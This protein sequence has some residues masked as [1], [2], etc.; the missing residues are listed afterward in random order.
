MANQKRLGTHLLL[1]SL[2]MRYFARRSSSS[3]AYL[4]PPNHFSIKCACDDNNNAFHSFFETFGSTQPSSTFSKWLGH[5]A[6]LGIV[7]KISVST[8]DNFTN[9]AQCFYGFYDAKDALYF[10]KI[11]AKISGHIV[12]FSYCIQYQTPHCNVI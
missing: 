3:S 5:V 1:G 12:D 11:W 2:N 9:I 6:F 7:E 10:T 8:S 4:L